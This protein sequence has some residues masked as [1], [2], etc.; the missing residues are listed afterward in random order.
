MSSSAAA[1]LS[2][3][4]DPSSPSFFASM[5]FLTTHMCTF[6]RLTSAVWMTSS[7]FPAAAL[8]K[9]SLLSSLTAVSRASAH[10]SHASLLRSSGVSMSIPRCSLKSSAKSIIQSSSSYTSSSFFFP[11][12]CCCCCCCKFVS[13]TMRF[14]GTLVWSSSPTGGATTSASLSTSETKNLGFVASLSA[15][16]TSSLLLRVMTS[17]SSS[18]AV[19]LKSPRPSNFCR[20]T[21]LRSA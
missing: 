5:N 11:C 17:P 13:S 1:A 7:N 6:P 3:S 15:A 4:T 19:T 18:L 10:F 14:G 8:S 16:L 20:Q 2:T 9:A 12:C 21:D